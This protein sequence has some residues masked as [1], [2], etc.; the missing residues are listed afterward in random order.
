M[1]NIK[2]ILTFILFLFL[3]SCRIGTGPAGNDVNDTIPNISQNILEAVKEDGRYTTKDSVAAYIY[4]FHK[5]PTN[6]VN[7]A[8]AQSM[9]EAKGYTF[10]KWNFNPNKILGVMVGGDYFG[11]NEGLLP[12]GNYLEA[13]VDYFGDNRGTKRLVYTLD[14]VVYYTA[15]HYETFT[16]MY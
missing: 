15:N 9:Y 12:A 3:C 16:K 2:I 10:T 1:K 11:N 4:I 5:L 14:G 6:Y 7:K 13:D 8:T